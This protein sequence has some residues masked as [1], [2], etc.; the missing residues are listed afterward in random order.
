MNS[1]MN[2][3]YPTFQMYQAL[4]DQLLTLLTDEDLPIAWVAPTQL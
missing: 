2:E 3:Y 1:I 4:R